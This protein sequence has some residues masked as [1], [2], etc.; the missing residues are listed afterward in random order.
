MTQE[1]NL[2]G[3][4]F[5]LKAESGHLLTSAFGRISSQSS[6]SKGVCNA[7]CEVSLL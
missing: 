6:P 2:L 5:T 4:V 7:Q 1:N 3:K